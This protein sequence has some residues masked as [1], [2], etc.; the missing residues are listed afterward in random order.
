[1]N[2]NVEIRIEV[3]VPWFKNDLCYYHIIGRHDVQYI[4]E[5]YKTDYDNKRIHDREMKREEYIEVL[6]HIIAKDLL[7]A[8]KKERDKMETHDH[9]CW[10]GT[11][12][13]PNHPHETGEN[14]CIRYMVEPP[15]LSD[16]TTMYTYKQQRGYYQHPCGCWSR[17][18]GST[19]SLED[20]E[21]RK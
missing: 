4:L 2:N 12:S 16:G 14:G 8:C 13:V 20:P 3:K 19:N 10:C 17:H 6:S 18:P 11:S 15:D 9:R 7:D 5:P 21:E 1:M